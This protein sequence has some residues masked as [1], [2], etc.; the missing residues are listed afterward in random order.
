[1]NRSALMVIFVLG[2]QLQAAEKPV[3]QKYE[4][5][6]VEGRSL[7]MYVTRPDDWTPDDQRPAILFF[8]GGGWVGGAPGQFTQHSI[9]F[10]STRHRVLSGA[11]PPA[12]QKEERSPHRLHS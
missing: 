3:G 1:M 7:A 10:A 9:Y 4:Y 12:G 5:K 2:G 11:V 6:Q 8:H